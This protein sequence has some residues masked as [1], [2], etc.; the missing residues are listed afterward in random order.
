MNKDDDLN[1]EKM[2]EKCCSCVGWGSRSGTTKRWARATLTV[3]PLFPPPSPL[4]PVV[5]ADCGTCPTTPCIW[6]RCTSIIG[7]PKDGK[8]IEPG[9]SDKL[10]IRFDDDDDGNNPVTLLSTLVELAWGP[11]SARFT[12]A[13][14]RCPSLLLEASC[15]SSFLSAR[16]SIVSVLPKAHAG[17]RRIA[18]HHI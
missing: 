2:V 6:D 18:P 7:S 14:S 13:R 16:S 9:I 4:P 12:T 1:S 11:P 8:R 17:V 3:V 15:V 5:V 10:G